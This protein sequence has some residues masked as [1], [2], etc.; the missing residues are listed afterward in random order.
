MVIAGRALTSE[1]DP[2]LP[3]QAGLLAVGL[4]VDEIAPASYDLTD[5]KSR[6][7][8][9]EHLHRLYLFYERYD[10]YGNSSS[11]DTSVYGQTAFPE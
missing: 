2:H 11:D 5:H 3:R 1:L 8:E 9:V 6:C 10:Y 7:N 4:C